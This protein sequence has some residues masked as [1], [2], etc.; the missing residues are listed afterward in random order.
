MPYLRGDFLK[1]KKL[2]IA[3]ILLIILLIALTIF[4]LA[5]KDKTELRSVRSQKELERIYY[6]NKEVDFEDSIFLKVLSMPFT[7]FEYGP[8]YC[9]T[10]VYCCTI[11]Y[12]YDIDSISKSVNTAGSTTIGSIITSANTTGAAT[13]VSNNSSSSQK[14]FSTTNIQVENVDEADI[15]KTDGDYIYSL[16]ENNV[17]ITD[18]RDPENIKIA[19]KI[20]MYGT[21]PEDILLYNNKLVVIYSENNSR[22]TYQ[23]NTFVVIYDITNKENPTSVK[24]FTLYEPYYTCR[25]IDNNL[26][27]IASGKLRM[28]NNEVA[29]YY[30]EDSNSKEIALKNIHYLTTVDTNTQTLLCKVDLNNANEN[31]SVNSY[32]IDISNAY[33]SQNAIYLLNYAYTGH[34][35]NSYNPPISSLF[36]LRGVWGPAH[37]ENKNDDVGYNSQIYNGGGGI[38]Q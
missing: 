18:V 35:R 3:I 27:V 2:K 22:N 28:E 33:V 20:N 9:S 10:P 16:S 21:V 4:W 17:I 36:T 15:N 25:C 23:A 7:Y 30:T 6:G 14:D 1:V 34:Y 32:L 8:R 37:Y 13:S 11:D 12:S 29:T 31:I 26:Y 19:S 5:T 24:T 38:Y